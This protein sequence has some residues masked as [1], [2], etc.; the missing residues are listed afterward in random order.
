[1]EPRTEKPADTQN[2][3]G[4]FYLLPQMAFSIPFISMKVKFSRN[5]LVGIVGYTNYI[6]RWLYS[7]MNDFPCESYSISFS[8]A[9]QLAVT[10]LEN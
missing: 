1:M 2:I 10:G 3:L 6:H 5:I 7:I 4:G 8:M 9:E